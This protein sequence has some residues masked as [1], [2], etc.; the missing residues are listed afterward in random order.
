MSTN[1]TQGWLEARL[2]LCAAYRRHWSEALVPTGQPLSWSVG[3]LVGVALAVLTLSGI[4]L[5]LAYQ[6]SL[7]GAAISIADYT[8]NVPYG[9]LIRDLHRVGTTMLFGVLFIELFRGAFYG[10]YR[11]GREF[12]WIVEILRLFACMAVGFLG[13]AMTGS[14]AAHG[15]LL[16][17][18][19]H[20]AAIPLF[21]HLVGPAFLGGAVLNAATAPRVAMAHE[22]IGFLVLLIAT[23]TVI[24][25]RAA[26]PAHPDGIA[27]PDPRM[28]TPRAAQARRYFTAFLV[29]ALLFAAIL[30]LDPG[31]GTPRTPVLPA[32]LAIPVQVTPPWYLLVFHGFARVAGSP[33]GGTLLTVAAFLL[34]GALPWLDRGAVGSCRQRPVYAGFLVLLAVDLVLLGIAAAATGGLW[35]TV[36]EL[37][38]TYAF[39][40]FLIITPLVTM[41]ETPRDTAASHSRRTA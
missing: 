35:T 33:G 32:A 18:A 4:W 31:L 22:A 41:L 2:P 28:M 10:T 15:A 26:P 34:L 17:M 37:A 1:P 36:A 16:A 39:A 12:A 29:F 7:S 8:R 9:W 11:N 6:P 24:A 20:L 19:A 3:P 14:P 5:G 23:L 25:S 21:G 30:V 13:F 38:T 40:H 27:S